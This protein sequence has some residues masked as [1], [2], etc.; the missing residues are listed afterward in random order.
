[1]RKFLTLL[2]AFL[3]CGI[4]VIAQEKSVSGRVVDDKGNGVPFASVSV[5]GL[6][7]GTVADADGNFLIRATSAQ[8]LVISGTGFAPK[9]VPVGTGGALVITVNRTTNTL[10]EV[11]VTSLGIR[12]EAKSLGYSTATLN[13]DQ[14]NVAKPVNVAAGLMGQV[15]G[16]QV[17]II[18]NGVNPSVRIQL[19]G[20]RHLSSDNQPLIVVDGL[21]VRSDFLATINP[22]DVESMNVLKSASAAALYGSE[23]TN[24]VIIITTKKGSRNGK[25]VVNFTQTGTMEKLAYF[26][27]LQNQFSGYGGE[28]GIF[29]P[30]TPYQFNATNPYTGFT[31]YIPF[32]NQSYGPPFDGNPANAYVGIPN[33]NGVA[34]KTP[35]WPVPGDSRKKFFNTGYTTQSDLS[36]SNGD[37]KNSNYIGIQWVDVKGVVPKDKSQR[38]NIRFAGKRTYGKFWYDYSMNYALNYSNT[39]GNDFTAGWPLY[40]TL[41]NTPANIPINQLKNWQD[42]NSFGSLNL[43][44]NA[45]YINPWW[46]IDNSRNTSKADNFQGAMSLNLKPFSWFT[47]TYRLSALV[48]STTTKDYRNQATFSPWAQNAFGPPIYGTPFSGNI[49]GANEDRS[50]LQR[51]LQQ[52][53]LLTFERKFGDINATMILGNTIWDRYATTNLQG[54]GSA[55]GD[56]P[57]GPQSQTSG[58]IIPGLYNNAYRF[59]ILY[60]SQSRSQT[61]LIGAYGD[62]QLGYKEFLFLHGN[63]RR[64]YSSLLAP[65]HNSYDVYGADASVVFSD[66]IP[67]LKESRILTFGKIR[68]AWSHTG[69]ITLPP[70][71]TVNTFNVPGPYPYGGLN[72]LTLNGTYNNPANVPEATN[73]KEVGVDLGFLKNRIN[74]SFNYYHDVNYNQ[75]F[76]VSISSATGFTSAQVN[77]AQTTS[78]G[79]EFDV[80]VKPVSTKD[81][82]WDVGANLAIQTTIVDKLYGSGAN[83]TKQIGIGNS[84]E[85]IVGKEFPQM[86]VTDLVRDSATGKVIV[87]HLTGYP[88]ENPTSISAGRTTPKYILGLTS[89]VTYKDLTLTV[90]GDYRGGY[91]FLN[92]AERDLDFTGAS[93]HTAS[94]GRQNFIYPNSVVL[95]NGK[96]VPNTNVYVQDGNL[97]FWVSSD[98]RNGLANYVENAAAWKVRVI[99]LTY[100]FTRLIGSKQN[101]LKGLKFTALCNNALMFRPKQN[102]FT[103]PEFNNG[104]VNG[105][106]YN[107]YYQLP[108][109]RQFKAI[110]S[111]T[112]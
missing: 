31:N 26:P 85:A 90:V 24:G 23:A 35:F 13:T 74:F 58:L 63:Y 108:P 19:R 43:Y 51:R 52:D 56:L 78:H 2:S 10:S 82:K 101:I 3:L 103:D 112:F 69:Q 64:D 60:T 62:L 98:Y 110:I 36:I 41:L 66:I 57:G 88:T 73:E 96:Y 89:S 67:V 72:T 65:G 27:A 83:A 104:N 106:G 46:Q 22:E 6:K 71:S 48:T 68:G 34:L 39:V 77:A 5:K 102:D 97:G 91:V 75:L 30:N 53:F 4:L 49:F 37:A 42:P 9:E 76:N 80:K 11:V 92:R 81:V 1:M 38:A 79:Y 99:S 84:N 15:A 109:T 16:A 7:S 40:W 105:L 87:D 70:Y 47:A 33:A 25:P 59:G 14:L 50:D 28:T 95:Q 94:N 12:R 100:D 55:I 86:Y 18:D 20:E 54:V 21:Q 61:R 107:T 45:Y 29:F 32:E 93:Q 17:S 8:S 44:P 111:L